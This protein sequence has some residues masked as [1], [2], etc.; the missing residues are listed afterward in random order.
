VRLNS[1]EK[2]FYVCAE[3]PDFY[4]HLLRVYTGTHLFTHFQLTQF[5]V[6]ATL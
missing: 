5:Q 1:V 4:T 6:Y 3:T 2:L